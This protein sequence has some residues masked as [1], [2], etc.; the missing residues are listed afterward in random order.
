MDSA[1]RAQVIDRLDS[2]G[3]TALY[4]AIIQAIDTVGRQAGRRAIVIFSDGEDQ[5]SHSTQVAAERRV[6][7]SDATVY[8]I[9]Q[10]RAAERAALQKVLQRFADVSGGRAFFTHDL[11]RLDKAFQE[12]IED[13]SHQYLLSY[14]PPTT[15]PGV[16]R[17]I[18]VSVSGDYRV[19]ARQGYRLV[20][21]D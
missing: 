11:E 8:V 17:K 21:H 5:S 13:L 14:A 6:E 9:G 20:K 19:R 2:W 12:I 4:D 15:A 10:G 16:W 3:G 7:G 1:K 18:K